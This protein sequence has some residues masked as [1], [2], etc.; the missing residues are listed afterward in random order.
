MNINKKNLKNLNDMKVK[1]F[2]L[3][4]IAVAVAA[5]FCAAGS[6]YASDISDKFDSLLPAFGSAKIGERENAQLEWQSICLTNSNNPEKRKETVKLMTNQLNKEG[7]NNG[8]TVI[9]FLSLL[10]IIGDEESVSAIVPYLGKR[11]VTFADAAF[12]KEG[13]VLVID[14]A[15]RALGR[16]PGKK[17]EQALSSVNSIYARSAQIARTKDRQ[18]KIP[19]ESEMPQAIPF[20]QQA[21][22]DKYLQKYDS[23]NDIV[24]TQIVA[25]L[26][27]R[28][29]AKYISYI[30]NAI[31]SKDDTLRR[32]AII[33]IGRIN[34]DDAVLPL[35][36]ILFGT[37]NDASKAAELALSTITNKN[38]DDALIDIV[39]NELDQNRYG[40]IINVLV[41][42]NNP[43]SLT[44]LLAKIKDPKTTNRLS[45]VRSCAV[46]ATKA[47]IPDFV[48]AWA[49]TEDRAERAEI[50][51]IIAQFANHDASAVLAKRTPQNEE[52]MYSLLGRIGD[53]K[54]LPE[55]KQLLQT[56]TSEALIAIRE[57]PNASVASEL[58][59]VVKG[60]LGDYSDDEKIAALRAF[61][62]V[63][64]LPQDQQ[65]GVKISVEQQVASLIEA[66]KLATRDDERIL[67]LTRIGSVRHVKS[68]QFALEQIN[69]EKLQ[70][71]AV[72]TILD[73][74]HH[75]ELRRKD[76]D[77]FKAALNTVLQ[78]TKDAKLL[79]RANRY[80]SNF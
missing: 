31:N 39:S 49:L 28:G 13:K 7:V 5:L 42:R 66:F 17:A 58:I 11:D 3:A 20:A 65:G 53:L 26:G 70:D 45:L 51:K 34:S 18:L 36:E 69:N 37:D 22:V 74:A 54:T 29:D 40:Q 80:L 14:E 12:E 61:I 33:A 4:A 2:F 63:I 41:K 44:F 72:K 25:N 24:K 16:I 27:A 35:L 32:A 48:D 77:V 73:L 8:E 6:V 1:R 30:K 46:F 47:N 64:S 76:A 52:K 15:A 21:D 60:E 50:E 75:T 62:R 38:V 56:S 10:G 23:Q 79:E 67:A 19:N 9:A 68:L 43:T 78:K 71:A 57:W 59:D 55:L